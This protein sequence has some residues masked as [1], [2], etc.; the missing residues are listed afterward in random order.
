[1]TAT[2][3]MRSP[4]K[5]VQLKDETPRELG[6]RV[7]KL[8]TLPFLKEARSNTTMQA[9]LA[10]LYVEALQNERIWNDIKKDAPVRL[11]VAVALAKDSQVVWEKVKRKK[12]QKQI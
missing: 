10:D 2:E 6:D 4:M 5:L 11:S 3:A 12:A 9:Q 7:E 1:M 8:A